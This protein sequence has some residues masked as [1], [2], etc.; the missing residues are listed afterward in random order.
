VTIAGGVRLIRAG[1]KSPLAV[2]EDRHKA[3][4]HHRELL[5]HPIDRWA[6]RRP[7]AMIRLRRRPRR[8]QIRASSGLPRQPD[9]A[10]PLSHLADDL[11][12]GTAPVPSA[13]HPPDRSSPTMTARIDPRDTDVPPA[14]VGDPRGDPAQTPAVPPPPPTGPPGRDGR[15]LLTAGPGMIPDGLRSRRVPPPDGQPPSHPGKSLITT[16]DMPWP[17]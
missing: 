14:A 5:D 16:G 1:Q 4:A 12:R 17:R 13:G 11:E 2:P 6:R 9:E 8:I 10:L 3:V 7:G 15:T